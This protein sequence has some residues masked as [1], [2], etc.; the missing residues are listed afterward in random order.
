MDT[1]PTPAHVAADEEVQLPTAPYPDDLQLNPDLEDG[2]S[3]EPATH[4]PNS[5]TTDTEIPDTNIITPSADVRF[6]ILSFTLPFDE[7][8][9]TTIR[10]FQSHT[11]LQHVNEAQQSRLVNYLDG[12]LLEIQRRFI[13]NQA[14]SDEIYP[15]E[16]LLED[17]ARILDLV[18]FLVNPTSTLYGQDEYFIRV[19]GD[20]EDWLNYYD[21]PTFDGLDV[22]HSAAL[23]RLFSFMQ[24]LDSRLSFLIDGF[25]VSGTLQSMSGTEVVR[26]V[27]IVSR[28][29]FML[30]T[31]LDPSRAKLMQMKALGVESAAEVLNKLDV[32]I[33]R[34]FEGVLDRT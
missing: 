1:P 23:N 6:Q 5:A 9:D 2:D 3:P 12:E 24:S 18:W 28:I 10:Q 15:L 17:V 14:D 19:T 34:L 29:R 11:G 25:D 13:K 33:G 16:N 4:P 26:L 8:H 30:I 31:K 20:L 27:P 22:N 7:F 21:F 32:E